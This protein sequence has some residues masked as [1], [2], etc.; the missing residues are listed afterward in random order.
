M[1]EIRAL[2]GTTEYHSRPKPRDAPKRDNGDATDTR[3]V[4]KPKQTDADIAEGEPHKLNL[5]V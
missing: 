4:K 2:A 1:S 5:S 3:R